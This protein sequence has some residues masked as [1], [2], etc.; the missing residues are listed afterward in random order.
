MAVAPPSLV[1]AMVRRFLWDFG[2][3]DALKAFE[4]DAAG[5]LR[6]WHQEQGAGGGTSEPR[7]LK[8][9]QAVLGEYAAMWKHRTSL[10]NL[11]A[12]NPIVADLIAVVERHADTSQVSRCSNNNNNNPIHPPLP[13]WLIPF[14]LVPWAGC[15][16]PQELDHL[17]AAAAFHDC[18][19]T[20]AAPGKASHGA[21]QH[22]QS[23][24][25]SASRRAGQLV[26]D[27]ARRIEGGNSGKEQQQQQQL[28]NVSSGER[29]AMATGRPLNSSGA[30][31][32][33]TRDDPRAQ[34][35]DPGEE[36]EEQR[37]M[38]HH[39]APVEDQGEEPDQE[40]APASEAL[41]RGSTALRAQQQ[42]GSR[43]SEQ[44]VQSDGAATG[45]GGGRGGEEG[46][47]GREG[48]QR[49]RQRVG[50]A[51]ARDGDGDEGLLRPRG[52]GARVSS[53]EEEQEQDR[54]SRGGIG[55]NS[56][57]GSGAP[58]QGDGEGGGGAPRVAD[59]SQVAEKF[60]ATLNY[61]EQ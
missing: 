43:G 31:A 56:N 48:V 13:S 25:D 54:I 7:R 15:I 50:G 20:A 19:K 46:I 39:E 18:S 34:E 11:S 12:R 32:S 27:S 17:D 14:P 23:P 41:M 9:L 1:A 55:G 21:P 60:L 36:E 26:S 47:S 40:G 35:A 33:R 49:K 37:R 30:V 4:T 8:D 22:I 42:K 2:Y 3:H 29:R 10:K 51:Q 53:G 24:S 44:R 52:E 28:G 5:L 57:R 58:G 61:G 6:R 16:V 38:G 45:S 59:L